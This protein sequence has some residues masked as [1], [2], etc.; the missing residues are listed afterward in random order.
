MNGLQM[1]AH[2]NDR[3][4]IEVAAAGWLARRDR[5]FTTEEAE[6]FM[7][8]R[9]ADPRHEAAV[10]ELAMV[11]GALDVLSGSGSQQPAGGALAEPP[12]AEAPMQVVAE[13]TQ[14][15]TAPAGWWPAWGLAAAL[16]IMVVVSSWWR[17]VGTSGE[18]PMRYETMVGAQRTIT[19]P[20][21]SEVH[22]NTDSAVSV[23]F[24]AGERRVSLERGEV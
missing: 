24:D 10:E 19:L 15:R 7:R 16:A 20:D 6:A 12:A 5:G 23:Q 17:G 18:P 8:W 21:G 13:R 9:V 3:D 22:L 1:S 14:A 2:E 4:A 11:W